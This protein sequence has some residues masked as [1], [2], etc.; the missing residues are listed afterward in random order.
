MILIVSLSASCSTTS[1]LRGKQDDGKIDINFIQINDVYEIAGV[2]GGKEG[3]LARIAT[4]KKQYLLTNSNSFALIAGDFLS[5]SVYNSLQ[6]QGKAVRGKQMIETL[7]EAGIDFAIFGN[8]EF[9]IKENELQERIDESNFKWISTNTFHKKGSQVIPFSKSSGETIP[10]TRILELQDADGTKVKVGLIGLCLPFNKADYVYY[11]DLLPTA[12]EVVNKL[13][14]SVD[15]VVAITHQLIGDDEKLAKELP[16]LAVI[17]GGHEHDQ[18]FKKIG[19]VYITKAMANARSAYV[20]KLSINKKKNKIKAKPEL[21]LI[22]DQIAK[23]SATNLVVEKWTKIAAD[24][25]STLGF[26][27]AKVIIDKGEPLDGREA[28]VRTHPTN[29]TRL[30]IKAIINAAPEADVVIMNSGSI[31][32]DDV[33]PIPV[34]QYDVIRTLPFG[35]GIRQVE[36]KGSMLTRILEQGQKNIGN[37]GYLLYNE[38]IKKQNDVWF[39]NEQI[40]NAS[41]VYRVALTEF[42]FTGKESN[43]DF[44]NP[45]NPEI[46][47]VYDADTARSNSLSDI[48]LTFIRY[49]EKYNQQF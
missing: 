41:K 7:N 30:L 34:T 33:L 17:M 39:L 6:Y 3:G 36:M 10:T 31:R 18:R 43:L 2:S 37:G 8:H 40:I 29:L 42:L 32:V 4:L 26:D 5:P 25:F 24:N 20:I 45:S 47:K 44:V 13:R 49:L 22:N 16:E 15:A 46:V 48:R 23:D 21:V 27:V 35:G 14:D 28:A 19:K 11:A 12:K 38:N 9:D 1:Q